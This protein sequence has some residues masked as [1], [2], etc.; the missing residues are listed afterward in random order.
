MKGLVAN[1]TTIKEPAAVQALEVT[2][3]SKLRQLVVD[4]KDTASALL[5]HGNLKKRITIIPL[6]SVNPRCVTQEQ[7][8]AAKKLVGQDNVDA[9]IDLVDF[10]PEFRP[11]MEHV[12]GSTFICKDGNSAKQV[13]FDKAIRQRS[14]SYEGDVFNP[15]GE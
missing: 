15:S 9:A 3:G 2:A 8:A 4:N 7:V 12:F 1:L 5:K 10:K 11:A 14:V 6:D 13:T